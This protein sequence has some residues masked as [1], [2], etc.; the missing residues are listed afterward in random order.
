M[1]PLIEGTTRAEHRRPGA[2]GTRAQHGH[3][4]WHGH[5]HWHWHWHGQPGGGPSTRQVIDAAAPS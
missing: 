5:W 1:I 3:G 2:H 4:H